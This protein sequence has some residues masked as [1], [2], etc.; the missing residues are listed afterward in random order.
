[1]QEQLQTQRTYALIGHGG[2][3]KTSVAEMLLHT[4][5]VVSRLGKI[6]EG[7]TC[8]DYEPEE[9]KRRGSIQPG[10]AH[11]EWN[12]NGHFLIDAPGDNNFI[13]DLSYTLT[14]ADGVVLVIDAIDGV[15]PLT[16]KIWSEARKLDLPGLA[17][18]NK[19]DRERADFE[20]AMNGLATVLGARTVPLYLPIGAEADFKGVVDVLAGKAYLF[21]DKGGL[22]ETEIPTDMADDAGMLLETSVENIAESSEE[23][24]EKYLEEGE[25]SPDEIMSGLHQG[26]LSGDLL[27]VCVGSA[28]NDRGGRLL[29]DAIQNLL[30]SPLEH[31][32]WMDE[33]GETRPSDPAQP[34]AALVF[35]TLADPFAGQLSVMRVLTGSISSD[36]TVFNPGK[37]HKEKFGQLLYLEGKKQSPCKV[38]VGPGAIVA[39]AKL[40]DTATGD[41]LCAEKAP[42]VLEKPVLTPAIISYA[43][44]SPEKGDEDKV[45]AAVQKLL[46]EDI[47]LKLSR[48]ED[49]GDILLSGMGQMHLEI[50]VEKAR[51]RYKTDIL[52]KTPKVPYRETIKGRAEVQG[53]HKKQTG[54]RGQF[55][56]CW[57]RME[58]QPRGAGY[59]F[60][61][62]IVGGAI[63]R[64]YIPAV[65]KGIQEAARRG[66]LAGYPLVDFKISLYD[67][68]YHNVDSSEMAFKI[69][70]SLAY[71]KAAEQ[72]SPTILEP[73]MLVS[74]FAPDE[75]MGDIIGDLSSRRGKVLG[76]D[77][78]GGITEI[79]AH[80]PMA[81]ILKYAPD[82]RSMTGGQGT[83]T[84][85]FALYEE[86]P[87]NIQAQIIEDS[88]KTEE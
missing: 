83:F 80:V 42:F 10:F 31:A 37:D 55:G 26:T 13:G 59:E 60:V 43:L 64:S 16:R 6:E 28:L 49:T 62:E 11:F 52:L 32:D 5:G 82:L 2:T 78:Q 63:P 87:G 65:D 61:D 3:G 15:K 38:A 73:I 76:S 41:M 17:F 21:D 24:M 66:I 47:N 69:A 23:L 29:L 54:G 30:P 75:F 72:C 58:P 9:V 84:M 48:N 51:R 50:A 40:K 88:R 71:K 1:M 14:A 79:K 22:T 44:A 77:S 19:M 67:G 70:G 81:E 8:L 4:A 12:K 57:I 86:C 27:P 68:S 20:T 53:R 39:V 25:L 7:T 46:D 33:Q 56:D 36:A 34:F 35:K 18:V 74:V 85:E 45:F